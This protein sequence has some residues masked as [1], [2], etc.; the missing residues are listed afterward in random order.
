M[1]TKNVLASLVTEVMDASQSRELSADEQRRFH[2]QF[3]QEIS[4]AIEEIREN[5]RRA[6][7]DVKDIAVN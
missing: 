1:T 7:E 6:Y 3:E 4:G 5:R 2:N